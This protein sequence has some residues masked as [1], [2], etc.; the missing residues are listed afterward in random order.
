MQTPDDVA[1]MLRLHVLGWGAKRIARELGIS[2]NTVKHYLRQGGWSAYR[3]PSRS[4]ALDGLESWLE[5][6]FIQHGGNADVV[7]QELARVHGISVSLRTVERG[8]QPFRQQLVAAARATLRFETPPGRQLQIDFGTARVTIGPEVVRISLFVATLGYSRRPFVAAFTHERQSAWLAG[9]EG[10]FAHFGGIVEQVLLDN[11]KALVLR[12]D[13]QTREV[14]FNERF[15]A[16]ARY[17]GFTPRA[18]APY[19]ARTKGKDESGVKYVKRNAIAGRSFASWEELQ[20][21]LTRWM[22]EVADVRVHGTTGERPIERF[23]RDERKALRPLN[24][25]P[26][27]QQSRELR[28]RVASDACVEADT[29]AYSVPWRLIGQQVSVQIAETELVVFQGTQ[30]VARHPVCAGRRQR[31]I[32]PSHLVGIVGM[33]PRA[34]VASDPPDLPRP[35]QPSP[36]LRPLAEY[37]AVAGGAW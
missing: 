34:L 9:I 8:V 25:R 3:S 24:G 17:W 1:A 16:F 12:H 36:L 5:Q 10:A 26:P 6:C 33:A 22:R 37:E 30:E 23:E 4:K 14:S 21:H 15:I 18:C 7:R 2:K 28:R 32:N 27:F 19:R 11:P 29:N 31:V 20:S 13:P 35:P